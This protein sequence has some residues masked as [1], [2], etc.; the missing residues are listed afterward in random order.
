MASTKGG[1]YH[2]PCPSCGGDDRFMFWPNTG[3]YY[4]RQCKR[5]GDPIQFCRDFLGMTFKEA[6]DRVGV[7]D[8]GRYERVQEFEIQAIKAPTRSWQEK[9]NEFVESCSKRL[10]IDPE[11]MEFIKNKY[12]LTPDTISRFRIGWNPEKKFHRKSDWGI[13][14][15]EN[16]KWICLPKGIIIPSFCSAARVSKIKIRREEW[17]D[18]DQYGKYQEIEGSSNQTPIYG[19]WMNEV[20]MIVESELDAMCLC[21]EVG[22]FCTCVALGGAA[23]R[24]DAMTAEW[25]KTRRLI[26]YSLDFDDA[27]DKEYRYWASTFSQLGRWR[28]NSHKSPADSFVL[29]G[30]ILKDWFLA[31]IEFWETHKNG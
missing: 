4:C 11:A 13:Q 30:V 15:T 31:G 14:E 9:A 29:G 22:E 20:A 5:Q 25:L 1:E 8:N 27:G 10:L 12:G 19:L 6:K 18:G 16:R 7:P 24:P 17:I 21:Q 28:S 3:R 23:K 2:S 26:L